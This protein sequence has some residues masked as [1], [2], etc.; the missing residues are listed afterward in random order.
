MVKP[1]AWL[2]RAPPRAKESQDLS[3]ILSIVL[4]GSHLEQ[5]V[6]FTHN[7]GSVQADEKQGQ[8]PALLCF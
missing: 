1:G 3:P 8:K 5:A 7:Q 6:T 2:S 4:Q